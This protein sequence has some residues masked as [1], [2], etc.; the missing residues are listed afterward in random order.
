MYDHLP[1]ADELLD[2]RIAED[3]RPTVTSTVDGDLILGH[4]CLRF[5]GCPPT[6]PTTCGV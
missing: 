3:W 6:I 1:S 2:A 5:G 4:A